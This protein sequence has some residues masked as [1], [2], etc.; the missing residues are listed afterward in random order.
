MN[1]RSTTI[2]DIIIVNLCNDSNKIEPHPYSIL[3]IRIS[4]C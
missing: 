3:L 1:T 4:D 2:R